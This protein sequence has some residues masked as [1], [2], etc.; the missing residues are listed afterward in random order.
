MTIAQVGDVWRHPTIVP[1]GDHVVLR[2]D[3]DN[4]LLARPYAAASEYSRQPW[5]SAEVYELPMAHLNS[6]TRQWKLVAA[7]KVR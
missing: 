4:V 5:L 6:G 7:G 1:F 3:G 2:V